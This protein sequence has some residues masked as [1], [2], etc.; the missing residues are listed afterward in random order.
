MRAMLSIET[1][2]QLCWLVRER[3]ERPRC[4]RTANEPDEFP[5]PHETFP[6][7]EDDTLPRRA[8]A[9]VHHNKNRSFMSVQG[10]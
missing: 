9:V 5:S 10:Q 8:A 6:D 4:C 2:R 1:L 3:R 7:S